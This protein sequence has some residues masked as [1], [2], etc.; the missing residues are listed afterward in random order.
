MRS[1]EERERLT[2]YQLH[3]PFSCASH[4]IAGPLSSKQMTPERYRPGVPLLPSSFNQ[5]DLALVTRRSRGSAGR[6]LQLLLS[7][8][9]VVHR[10]L[11]PGGLAANPS[12]A[13]NCGRSIKVMSGVVNPAKSERY[14]PVTPLKRARDVTD[15]MQGFEP[16]RE[17]ANLSGRTILIGSQLDVSSA[18]VLTWRLQAK[19]LSGRPF[20]CSLA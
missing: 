10:S 12:S 15:S 2:R 6:W 9:T 14:R 18:T 17:S 11:K 1:P 4:S 8:I 7:G 13:A 3:R 19:L 5:Q 16:C 20:Y